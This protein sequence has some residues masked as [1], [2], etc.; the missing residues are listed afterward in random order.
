MGIWG[1]K[2]VDAG[3]R[4][5]PLRWATASDC[6]A[7]GVARVGVDGAAGKLGEAIAQ[8]FAVAPRVAVFISSGL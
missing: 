4:G 3:L 6:L 1:V 7:R 2:E 5:A 8:T